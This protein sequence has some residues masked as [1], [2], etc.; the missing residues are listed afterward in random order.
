MTMTVAMVTFDARDATALATW[1]ARQ[2][3]GEITADHDGWFV[4]VAPGERGG[5]MLA[6]QQVTDPTPGKNRVHLDLVAPDRELEVERLLGEGALEVARHETPSFT[7]V[8]LA[9]PEGNQFC[10]SQHH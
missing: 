7:W 6:F 2:T 1:W 9:D 3:G 5:P 10:V 8:V 4:M